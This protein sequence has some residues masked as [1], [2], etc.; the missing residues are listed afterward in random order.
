MKPNL[1]FGAVCKVWGFCL[2]PLLLGFFWGSPNGIDFSLFLG[3]LLVIAGLSLF[4][5][6]FYRLYQNVSVHETQF[7]GQIK[8]IALG[9]LLIQVNLFVAGIWDEVWHLKYG[10]PF[11]EDFFWRPHLLL[12]TGFGLVLLLGLE[13]WL[14]IFWRM[15]GNLAHRLQAEPI[16]GI[17]LFLLLF[18]MLTLPLDPFWH[19]LYGEDISVWSIPHALMF[20][21]GLGLNFL[22]FSAVEASCSPLEKRFAKFLLLLIFSFMAYFQ[23]LDFRAWEV[24]A[25]HPTWLLP[26]LAVLLAYGLWLLSQII[27]DTG[28]WALLA[29]SLA[30]L[31]RL[32][33]MQVFQH[34]SAIAFWQGLAL[35]VPLL[36][37]SLYEIFLKKYFSNP[38]WSFFLPLIAAYLLLPF[39]QQVFVLNLSF[40]DYLALLLLLPLAIWLKQ[41]LFDLLGFLRALAATPIETESSPKLK[42]NGRLALLFAANGL[43]LVFWILTATPPA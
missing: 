6:Q 42:F 23:M 31:L 12:Y 34:S 41:V 2:L 38:V 3:L 1:N 7:K 36:L 5:W 8:R 28:L 25:K 13:A 15:K 10:I 39:Y 29:A 32:G 26:L 16:L 18:L 14:S 20:Y 22:C 30:L 24:V 27:L 43:F 11:G 37:F 40:L 9:L 33:L 35:L 21:L 4:F 19:S 17:F